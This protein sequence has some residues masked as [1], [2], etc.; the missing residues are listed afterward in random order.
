MFTFK[1][2]SQGPASRKRAG[3][4]GAGSGEEQ[5]KVRHKDSEAGKAE[6]GD[7]AEKEEREAMSKSKEGLPGRRSFFQLNH[8]LFP[9]CKAAHIPIR[10]SWKLTATQATYCLAALLGHG[11][12]PVPPLLPEVTDQHQPPFFVVTFSITAGQR[13]SH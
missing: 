7:T 1:E 5:D 9:Q 8:S 2:H 12:D 10:H 13:Q 6:K 3:G 11:Q 4:T